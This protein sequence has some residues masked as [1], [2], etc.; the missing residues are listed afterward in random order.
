MTLYCCCLLDDKSRIIVSLQKIMPDREH[1]TRSGSQPCLPL[2]HTVFEYSNFVNLHLCSQ[3]DSFDSYHSPKMCACAWVQCFCFSI[4]CAYARVHT[5]TTKLDAEV[6]D[7][8]VWLVGTKKLRYTYITFWDSF[9][10]SEPSS[11]KIFPEK[12]W[13]NASF[14]PYVLLIAQNFELIWPKQ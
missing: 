9:T 12:Y 3:C 11:G 13:K 8:E 4:C 7:S 2:R 14:E 6:R 10:K 5:F 1:E